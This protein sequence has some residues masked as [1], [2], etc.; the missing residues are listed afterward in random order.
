[1]TDE[2]WDL[3]NRHLVIYNYKATRIEKSG[4]GIV[5][6]VVC[7]LSRTFIFAM[8]RRAVLQTFRQGLLIFYYYGRILLNIK[9]IYI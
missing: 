7:N 1:M 4:S 5:G 2:I 3:D 6:I 9:D 8:L